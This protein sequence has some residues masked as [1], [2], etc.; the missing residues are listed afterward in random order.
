M[1]VKFSRAVTYTPTWEGNDGLPAVEQF[2]VILKPMNMNDLF[3][4]LDAL[5]G[6][7]ESGRVKV[8]M[9]NLKPMLTELQHLLPKYVEK[10]AGLE[11]DNGVVTIED[12]I[13]YP[14]YVELA[15]ELLMKLAEIS[16]PSESAT[17]N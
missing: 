15:I 6:I 2:S 5:G 9:Q 3:Q 17:K 1:K 16:N 14:R 7:D 8:N 4:T 13:T 12:I 10:I 11:D